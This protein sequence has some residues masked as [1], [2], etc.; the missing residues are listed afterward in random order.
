MRWLGYVLSVLGV[1]GLAVWAYGQNHQTQQAMS[2]VRELRREIRQLREA[3]DVQNAEW[4]FLNRPDRLRLLADL[5]FERL[6]LLALTG[7]RFGRIDEIAY[8]L[9]AQPSDAP[10]EAQP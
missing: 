1:I 10:A 2:E 4:A 9:P 6:Q 5:N 3:L 7:E 8:P